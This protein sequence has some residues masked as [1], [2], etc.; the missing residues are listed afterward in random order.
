[1]IGHE[2]KPLI[3]KRSVFCMRSFAHVTPNSTEYVWDYRY[4]PIVAR[5][6][7]IG[8]TRRFGLHLIGWRP[9]VLGIQNDARQA[10][11]HDSHDF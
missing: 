7:R 2:V 9:G 6:L 8:V 3:T 1:M 5:L 11:S 4:T 10:N